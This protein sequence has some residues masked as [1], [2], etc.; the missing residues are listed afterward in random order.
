MYEFYFSEYFNS[1]DYS[2]ENVSDDHLKSIL[3]PFILGCESKNIKIIEI[4][5]DAIHYMIGK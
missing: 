5:L 4:S 3:K 2:E 1:A